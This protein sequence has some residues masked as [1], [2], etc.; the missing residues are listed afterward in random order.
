MKT[1][2]KVRL[3]EI[4]C[5]LKMLNELHDH[6][7]VISLIEGK[8]FEREVVEQ[9][10]KTQ[11]QVKLPEIGKIIL[12]LKEIRRK[13][14]LSYQN[15][16]Y[17]EEFYQNVIKPLETII[18][19]ENQEKKEIMKIAEKSAEILKKETSGQ[20]FKDRGGKINKLVNKAI[21]GGGLL[22]LIGYG[23]WQIYKS[24][25]KKTSHEGSH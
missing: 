11:K 16:F 4:N 13:N 1:E 20:T 25:K 3:I 10:K 15:V 7:L 23:S 9:L 19:L 22:T 8:I 17:S 18:S 5:F 2:I 21:I 14:H 6:Q 12:Y 24:L